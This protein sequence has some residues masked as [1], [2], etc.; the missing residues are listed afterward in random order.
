MASRKPQG[1]ARSSSEEPRRRR[2]PAKKGA[3]KGAK[4]AA[5]RAAKRQAGR[6]TA[7]VETKRGAKKVARA[8][9]RTAQRPRASS[10]KR[11]ARAE[12]TSKRRAVK[13]GAKKAAAKRTAKRSAAP[14]KKGAKKAAKRSATP[15]KKAAKRSATPRT[16]APAPPSAPRQRAAPIRVANPRGMPVPDSHRASPPERFQPLEPAVRDKPELGVRDT[17]Q[18]GTYSTKTR[19]AVAQFRKVIRWAQTHLQKERGLYDFPMSRD[20]K[21]YDNNTIDAQLT[22]DLAPNLSFD[23]VE[24]IVYMCD[25]AFGNVTN[26]TPQPS[27]VSCGWI[28]P[29]QSATLRQMN[30]RD[31]KKYRGRLR[32][33]VN[34]RRTA[35]VVIHGRRVAGARTETFLHA[36]EILRNYVKRH[37]RPPEGFYVRFGWAEDGRL[38]RRR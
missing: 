34:Y 37:G 17:K 18:T 29:A 21:P 22:I 23:R 32:V 3:K 6:R 30:A 15:V 24:Q 2:L 31:Y 4:K 33:G 28:L 19:Q 36:V 27:F 5:K 9:K 38:Y 14:V 35:D 12:R 13:K 10:P 1:R 11:S 16:R 26:V 7:A 20:V 8:S 25:E